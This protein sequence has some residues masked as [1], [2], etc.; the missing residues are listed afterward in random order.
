M[1]G[2]FGFACQSPAVAQ[3]RLLEAMSARQLRQPWYVEDRWIDDS[4]RVAMGRLA[5]SP[6]ESMLQPARCHDDAIVAVVAGE[7]YT[8]DEARRELAAAGQRCANAGPA[9]LV[10]RGYML[11]GREFFRALHG[12]FAAAIWD[13]HKHRLVLVNDRFGMK[14]LY[15]AQTRGRLLFGS[16]IQAL[17]ADPSVSRRI[18][19]RGLAQFFTFGQLLGED[20]LLEG[21]R[22][23][24]PAAWLEYDADSDRV[25]LDRYWRL[26]AKPAART[27]SATLDRIDGA[28]ARAVQRCTA[29]AD[30][31]GLSLSGGMDA[32][33]ILAVAASPE[34]P[35]VTL[36]SGM[37]GNMDHRAAGEMARVVGVPNHH[38]DLDASFLNDY[39]THLRHMVRLTDGQYLCQCIVLPT[40]PVYRELG[41]RVLMRGH[42]GELM[43]MS[44]AYNFSLDARALMLR[45]DAGLFDWL[46]PRLQAYMLEGVG[47][48]LFAGG[49]RGDMESLARG[50][51][52]DCLR[53]TS[54]VEPPPHRIWKLFLDQRLRRETALSMME[55]DAFVETRLPYLDADLVT[56]LFTCDPRLKLGDAIQ[57]EILQR[58]RPEFLRIVNVN[59]GTVVGAGPLRRS[60]STFRKRVLAKLGVKGYQPYERLGLWL[61]RELR[62]LVQGLLLN[63]R[64]LS[65]G[66]FDSDTVRNVVADHL[67]G[68]RNHT[69]LI[70]ALMIFETF[71]REVLEPNSTGHLNGCSISSASHQDRLA[72]TA[73]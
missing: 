1:P 65:R 19:L 67:A 52:T 53:A 29:N 43:H 34:R 12:K 23:L 3:P 25:T 21:V 45:D 56:E 16:S 55:F 69:Y 2:I 73:S 28:F 54:D 41:I 66:V 46:W 63:E 62:P 39:E 15:Y 4:G 38:V 64:T 13:A 40:F 18:G 10:L 70:L 20:T 42:A 51:L 11:S 36:T 57:A 5:L 59:T 50:S 71:H 8:G 72:C 37:P 68:R 24:P 14:Q 22:V 6:Q 17:L 9:E 49:H 33:T 31:L 35:I 7:I 44:K 26:D 32:R 48:R 47:A 58:R 60:V 27:E 30:G 61:R